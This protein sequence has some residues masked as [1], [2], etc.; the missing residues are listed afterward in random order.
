M[1]EQLIESAVIGAIAAV[2]P[3]H[4]S[5]NG[6][7]QAAPSG[8]V[9]GHE[10]ADAVAYVGVAVGPRAFETFTTPKAMFAVAVS[11]KVRD[12][13]DPQGST[14]AACAES[15]LALMQSWQTSLQD[16]KTAFSVEGFVP[17]GV[18]VEGGNV[19]RDDAARATVM[20][21]SFTIRGI[22]S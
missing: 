2:I 9:K 18:R 6:A 7:W 14:F 3:D 20:T 11:L 13:R 21:E 10:T 5:I 17:H 22:I 8:V 16:V 1:L 19:V 12:E 4:V 15:I